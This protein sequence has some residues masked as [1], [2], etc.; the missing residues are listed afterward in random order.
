MNLL[1]L[2]RSVARPP[3]VEVSAADRAPLDGALTSV[4][5]AMPSA[6]AIVSHDHRVLAGNQRFVRCWQLDDATTAT[7]D[8]TAWLG[9]MSRQCAPGADDGAAAA[10]GF[11]AH[12][13]R[14][15]ALRDGRVIDNTVAPL[16]LGDGPDGWI[17]V[18][19]DVTALAGLQE[20]RRRLDE[21]L[22]R[23]QG[24]S[25]AS[26][27]V[28][29]WAHD[30]QNL[31]C[32]M[33][34][35]AE[36]A[37]EDAPADTAETCRLLIA[38]ALRARKLVE[39]IQNGGCLRD[40]DWRLVDLGD[41]AREL[42][43]FVRRG[44]DSKIQLTFERAAGPAGL[45]GNA[46]QLHRVLLNLVQN[47][48]QAIGDGPGSVRLKLDT[49]RV[50]A[51]DPDGP[52]GGFAGDYHRLEVSDTGAGMSAEVLS[53]L[54]EPYFTTKAPGK[55]TGLGLVVTRKIVR[56][57]DGFMRV[58]SRPGAGSTFSLYFPAHDLGGALPPPAPLPTGT[59]ARKKILVADSRAV[60]SHHVARLLAHL[61][62][63]SVAAPANVAREILAQ[64]PGQ[65]AALVCTHDLP[66]ATGEPLAD[67]ARALR[68][69][70]PIAFLASVD[71]TCAR[72]TARRIGRA[73]VTP[74]N[75]HAARLLATLRDLGVEATAAPAPAP[76]L[77]AR[78][79]AWAKSA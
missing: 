5:E 75:L 31:L 51:G 26:L 52:D 46:E 6:V 17:I 33:V 63:A 19:R 65:F 34:L 4:L 24:G 25:V 67:Q 71:W 48:A 1:N 62:F 9:A 68:P 41:V 77:A 73:A 66:R 43:D 21:Q 78:P 45:F 35:C 76:T 58:A 16:P 44:L 23:V 2:P 50:E 27:A 32:G 53:R 3:A 55:G 15:I 74:K 36:R 59:A 7:A 20:E 79:A 29:G 64:S 70:L 72:A 47:A 69:D 54:F 60:F 49:I 40:P 13:C 38:N 22:L 57:H 18:G 56:G 10:A 37:R 39:R 8:F 42:T 61:G 14:E 30:I 12:W 11:P 28:S